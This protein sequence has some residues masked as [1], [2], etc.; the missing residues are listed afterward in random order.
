MSV[1]SRKRLLVYYG[2]PIAYKDIWDVDS[3]VNE[4]SNNYDIYVVGGGYQVP[5]HEAYA[6][7]VQ[8]ISALRARGVLVYGY[9][10]IG[11]NTSGL[12]VPQMQT[13]VDQWVTIGV[14][15]IFLDEFGFD[16]ANT[17]SR[18]ISIVDYVHG[19]G[20]PYCA[21]AWVYE[22]VAFDSL[23]QLT[24]PTND[25][26][27]TNF[28]TYNPSDLSLSRNPGDSYLIENFLF[29][30]SGPVAD[31]QSRIVGILAAKQV[32]SMELWALT[33]LAE[34]ATPNGLPNFAKTGSLKSVKDISAYVSANAY[35]FD[36]EVV[37]IG[38]YSFGSGGYPIEFSIANLPD[39]ADIPTKPSVFN[40]ALSTYFRKFGNVSVTVGNTGTIQ[41]VSMTSGSNLYSLLNNLVK[42]ITGTQKSTVTTPASISGLNVPMIAGGVYEIESYI[43]FTSSS[44]TNGITVGHTSPSGSDVR[45]EV[46]IPVGSPVAATSLHKTYPATTENSSGNAVGSGVSAINANHTVHYKALVTCGNTPGDF[47]LTFASKT[48]GATITIQANSVITSKRLA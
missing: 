29:D 40:P 42:K 39:N 11:Q 22:D 10:P 6:T 8:I 5:S 32:S 20:L 36:L 19:K 46:L 2:Y 18:Q 37:G 4:I 13:S 43:T 16:Y 31:A 38:G 1:K 15:G 21:N 44:T 7:T 14:D 28:Q 33:V 26:R 12:T 41:S 34:P 35:L 23:S 3:V 30:N 45:A 27:Y 47:Q 48:A 17:R 9:V 24:F 25:W